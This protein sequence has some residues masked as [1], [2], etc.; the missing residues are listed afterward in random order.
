MRMIVLSD[1]TGQMVSELEYTRQS[2]FERRNSEYQS[3]L[4]VQE[5]KRE[6]KRLGIKQEMSRSWRSGRVFSLVSNVFRLIAHRRAARSVP[7][8]PKMK[9][10]TREENVWKV[11]DEAE[12]KVADHLAHQLN[13]QWTL[14]SGY[15]NPK[16]EID[17]ILVGPRGVCTMEVKFLN[18]V[19]H[20]DGD[21]WW[22]DKYDRYGNRVETNVPI[23]DRRG[24]SPS[25]QLN[26]AA[27]M[28]QRFLNKRG[29]GSRHH[30]SRAVILT[31]SKS[32]IGET[33]NRKIDRILTLGD[34]SVKNL[35]PRASPRLNADSVE[36]LIQQIQGDHVF[37]SRSHS[38]G[39]RSHGPRRGGSRRRSRRRR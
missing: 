39:P 25:Q 15:R 35:Y 21:D 26:D 5:E 38:H 17:Q 16:G 23:A 2:D 18:G 37:H 27:S 3:E 24:R 30:V 22:R 8:Q 1:H 19:V 28:L 12:N 6:E 11:G 4:T 36:R 29:N 34:L 14:I 33:Y 32:R 9:A 20:F 7:P 13:D 31:H 10:A